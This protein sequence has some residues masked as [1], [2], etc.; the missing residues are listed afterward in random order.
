MTGFRFLGTALAFAM[1]ASAAAAQTSDLPP[2]R[3]PAAQQFAPP[4]RIAPPMNAGESK[5][6]VTSD[7]TGQAPR[8]VAPPKPGPAA[9]DGARSAP[10]G[11][12]DA[13]GNRVES[14]SLDGDGSRSNPRP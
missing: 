5:P 12:I 14:N 10:H 11:G 3:A 2:Q 1:G 8:T 4:A 7:T 13:N 6:G 9:G